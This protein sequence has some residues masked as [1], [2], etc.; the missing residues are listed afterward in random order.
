MCVNQKILA[1]FFLKNEIVF[2]D[3]FDCILRIAQFWFHTKT[4][5]RRCRLSMKIVCFALKLLYSFVDSFSM[6]GGQLFVIGGVGRCIEWLLK[7]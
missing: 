4:T 5:C 6:V 7:E 2:F 1:I 3:D